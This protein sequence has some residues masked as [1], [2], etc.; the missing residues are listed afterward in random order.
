[1]I[2]IVFPSLSKLELR[3][4]PNI[5]AVLNN[6]PPTNS[7]NNLT[8]LSFVDCDG[9]S[10][11]APSEVLGNLSKLQ[12][13]EVWYCGSI[14]EVFRS[15]GSN[16]EEGIV[17]T[18]IVLPHLSSVVL[19]ESPRLKSICSGIKLPSTVRW[20]IGRCPS[21]LRTEDMLDVTYKT[22]QYEGII[23]VT[24]TDEDEDIEETPLEAM[25]NQELT[26]ARGKTIDETDQ[27]IALTHGESSGTSS[28]R[29]EELI[30]SRYPGERS[31]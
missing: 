17:P 8:L 18:N 1:M 15:R 29:L 22:N 26:N 30:R 5:K 4:I 12:E 2:F 14:E 13:L 19:Q 3:A 20:T 31:S 25:S 24:S 16:D 10:Y 9:L 27:A 23:Y 28:D 21:F 11:V 7:F 6:T